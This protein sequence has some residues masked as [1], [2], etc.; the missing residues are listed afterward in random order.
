MF[1]TSGPWRALSCLISSLLEE[2]AAGERLQ[3]CPGLLSARERLQA[4]QT[5]CMH[6]LSFLSSV[7]RSTIYIYI[8]A[9]SQEH[10]LKKFCLSIH[11]DLQFAFPARLWTGDSASAHTQSVDRSA[12]IYSL[13][14]RRSRLWTGERKR[15]HA[16][17]R[18]VPHKLQ[19]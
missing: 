19:R 16:V 17:R 14:C 13:L 15:T 11:R 8:L 5:V 18:S 12:S 7:G 10:I 9:R 3:R 6:H 2:L 1:S 4:K